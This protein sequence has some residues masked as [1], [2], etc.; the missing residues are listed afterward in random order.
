ME[1]DD[2][3]IQN[4]IRVKMDL[5]Q[6][7]LDR[8]GLEAL[9]LRRVSSFAWAT[10]G[11]AS[12]VNTA[13]SDGASSLLITPEGRYLLTNNIEAP[14]LEKEEKLDEQGWEFRVSPWH[15]E[16]DHLAGLVG[17]LKLGVDGVFPGAVDLSGEVAWLRSQLTP[18]EVQRFRTLSRLCAEGMQQ[19]LESLRP[20][21][22]EYQIA[23]QLSL[24]VES[25]GVHAIVNL[26]ATDERIS[27]FR[28]PL[29]TQKSL[30]YYAMLVL[31]GRKWGLVCS[32]TR[33]VYF[34]TLPADLRRKAEAVASVDAT[35]IAATRPGRTMS[36]V[37]R[38]AKATYVETGFSEEWQLHHQ[39]GPAGYEPREALATS[40][41]IEPILVG[42]TYAWNP[43]ITGTKSED[44]IL[45]GTQGNEIL[46]EM[47]DWPSIDIQVDGQVFKRPAILEKG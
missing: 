1:P 14:R 37:F 20:G 38:R 46:T 13:T 11:A 26:I 5:I 41:S 16:E 36:E 44:T 22:T 29:P 34:G 32:L 7:L 12:Y 30:H 28:H 17:G 25:R 27:T 35:M 24:A 39:G 8:H 4:E 45:V 18:A 10:F 40:A 43:S 2:I 47:V 9:L 31:C 33:L 6:G 19:A 15:A 42:Q 21:M 23:G 3:P